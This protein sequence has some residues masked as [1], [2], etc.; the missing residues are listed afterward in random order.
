MRLTSLLFILIQALVFPDVNAQRVITGSV[1]SEGQPLPGANVLVKGTTL[2]TVTNADGFYTLETS[3][4]DNI[5]IISFIGFKPKEVEIGQSNIIDIELETDITTL[6]DVVVVGFGTQKKVNLTGSVLSIDESQLQG[7]GQ[8]NVSNLLSG[9]SPGVTILQQ[10]GNPGRNEGVIRIRGIGTLGGNVKNNPLILVDGIETG[11]LVEVDPND[12]ANISILKDAAAAAIYG[13]R[14]ANGVILITTK[15]GAVGAPK[16]NYSF[17]LG[18]SEAVMLPEKANSVELATL[19]NEANESVGSPILFR[20]AD[21]E[22][23]R[24]GN[25][26]LTHP[27]SNAVDRILEKRATRQAHNLSLSGGTDNTKYNILFGYTHEDGLMKNTGLKRYSMRVNLDQRISQ[28][29]S[30][31]LNLSATNRNVEEPVDG[32]GGILHR[33]YRE[34]ATD[35]IQSP[36][37]RWI[38]PT[39]SGLDHNATANLSDR[40]KRN[41]S[42]TRLTGTAFTEYEIVHNLKLKGI[43]AIISDFN[44]GTHI[45]RAVD[46]YSLDFVTERLSVSPNPSHPATTSTISKNSFYNYDLNLQ[47]LLTYEKTFG[48]HDLKILTGFN[49][50]KI[51]S[52]TMALSRRNLHPQLDQVNGASGMLQDATTGGT[53]V[54]YRLRSGFARVNYSLMDRYLV[55]SNVRYDGTSRFP[56]SARFHAFPSVSLGWRLSEEEFFQVPAVA[57]LKLRASWGQLGNQ[58]IGDYAFINRVD[59]NTSS[60]IIGGNMVTG[61]MESAQLANETIKWETTTVYN[62]GIDAE[63]LGGKIGLTAD[64]FSKN[65]DDILLLVEQPRILG[66]APPVANAGSMRNRGFEIQTIYRNTIGNLNF[67]V[68]GNI[69]YVQNEIT[70]LGDESVKIVDGFRYEEGKPATNIYGF[71]SEGLFVNDQEIQ[72]HVSQSALGGFVSAGDV[73]Y[74]DLNADGRI[75]NE[76]RA[77]LGSYFP[78]YNYGLSFNGRLRNFDLSFLWQGVADVDA[79]VTG[80]LARPFILSSSPL[81]IHYDG[82]AI[83][84]DDG[85]LVNSNAKFPRTLFNNPNNYTGEVADGRANSFFVKSTS[86]LKLRNIQLGYQLAPSVKKVMRAQNLRIF[87]SVD[88]VVTF[89][90]FNYYGMDPEIPSTGDPLP[91]YPNVRTFLL[92]INATF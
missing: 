2:G 35:P 90:K 69:S 52:E 84:A 49:Q 79:Y 80:R 57:S 38:F 88:N 54:D 87:C 31:G 61:A 7:R 46:L 62:L 32:V 67:N 43:G 64:A 26:P 1:T 91:A 33:A 78:S 63:F 68:Q 18:F 4:G 66:A 13:V 14:A 6:S 56:R 11:S 34:W 30:S 60:A 51:V 59:F 77:D 85:T 27:N 40:G 16:V 15:R 86:F 24:S 25:S 71:V 74:S 44:R 92:G 55:E 82:R 12:V 72:N 47:A 76:D 73:K 65:T 37:G 22:K 58:E 83:I 45:S 17:Q 5:L 50:R 21:M 36:D 8:T 70:S 75:D 53:L 9:Q 23:F 20:F 19:H 89:S 10:G 41:F 81:K 29:I 42:D 39:F 28:K 48:R 3:T